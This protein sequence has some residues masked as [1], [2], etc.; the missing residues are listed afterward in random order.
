M[1]YIKKFEK[2]DNKPELGDYVIVS[3][4]NNSIV[5]DFISNSVGR[6]VVFIDN[7]INQYHIRF[8]DIPEELNSFFSYD[9]RNYRLHEILYW[10]KDKKDL[11]IILQSNKFNI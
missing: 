9:C 2:N 4:I 5:Y 8:D 7:N 3:E 10:S 1:K 6:F 11:E